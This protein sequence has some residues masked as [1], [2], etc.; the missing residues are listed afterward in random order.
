MLASDVQA[1]FGLRQPFDSAGKFETFDSDHQRQIIAE[2]CSLVPTG[3]LIAISGLS[4]AGKT[5]LSRRIQAAL[6]EEGRV[7]VSKAYTVDKTKVTLTTLIT[8]LFHDLTRGKDVQIPRQS[9]ERE[10]ALCELVRKQRKPVALF[11]DEAQKLHHKTLTGLKHLMEVVAESDRLLSVVLV[12]MPK[13]RNDLRRPTMAEIG[14]RSTILELQSMAGS[15]TDYIRWLLSVCSQD[16]TAVAELMTEEAIDL[17][18]A[19]LR[20]PLQIERYLAAAF[21]EAF[22]LGVKPVSAEILDAVLSL[23]I[24]E[25]EPMLMEHGYD[26]ATLA[27]DFNAKPSEIRDF[28]AGKLEPDRTQALTTL[29]RA[30]GLPV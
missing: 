28:L 30:A 7:L 25:L 19:R 5:H 22:R 11:V 12:G 1:H 24:D 23:Q 14:H 15:Q 20:T 21:E 2:V 9:E 8:A 3:R 29:M 26:V 16:D 18:A 17:A 4:G 6:V 10:R 13:L 27:T